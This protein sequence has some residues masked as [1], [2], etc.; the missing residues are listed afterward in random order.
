M[1][2]EEFLLKY[3]L[4]KEKFEKVNMEWEEYTLDKLCSVICGTV[5]K[6]SDFSEEGIP[7]IKTANIKANKISFKRLSYVP[8]SLADKKGKSLIM[9]G[10]ILFSMTGNKMDGNPHNCV[11][12]VAMFKEEGKYVLN[13]RLCIIRV[14]SDLI[15][16]EF[17]YYYLSSEE[18]QQYFVQCNQT[19]GK[20]VNVSLADIYACKIKLPDMEVQKKIVEIQKALTEK[21]EECENKID[22]LEKEA[23]AY[24]EECYIRNQSELWEKGSL[25]NLGTIIAGGTPSKDKEEYFSEQG[26]PWIT[27]RDLSHKKVKFISRGKTDITESGLKHSSA[28]MLPAGT[29][30]FSSRAPIGYIAIATNEVTTNQGF[31]SVIPKE[32]VGT[33]FIY[34][35]LKYMLPQIQDMAVGSL[36][37]EVSGSVMKKLPVM[38][39]D[40]ETLTAFKN[41]CQPIFDKQIIL[42]D[43]KQCLESLQKEIISG[44]LS[45]EY[46][47]IDF[48]I[49]E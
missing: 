10:D 9:Y 49:N 47:M 41:F 44:I 23:Q 38:I 37:K 17:L 30:L 29:V 25:A 18:V 35:L 46:D 34:Y 22:I 8:E 16:R 14:D 15:D 1:Q 32:H 48:N 28:S 7:V 27:P 4:E 12:R 39:P 36:F 21:I 42:E 13:Q 11:G 20:Q 26:I 45:G 19:D 6:K 31:R 33:E 2:K 24:F 40:D 43:E 3:K 5:F